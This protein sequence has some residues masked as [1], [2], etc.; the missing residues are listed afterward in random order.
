MSKQETPRTITLDEPL[1]WHV[2][3]EDQGQIVE[4][5]WASL[6]TDG[7]LCRTTDRSDRT[8]TYRMHDWTPRDWGFTPWNGC[9]IKAG[10]VERECEVVTIREES[11]R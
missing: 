3:P 2:A 5:A 10:V 6:G 4:S 8:V 11:A 1:K 9:P 7:A